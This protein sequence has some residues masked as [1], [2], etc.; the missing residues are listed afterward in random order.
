[1]GVTF[2][3]PI[4]LQPASGDPSINTTAQEFRNHLV[5]A[6]AVPVGFVQG[7][8]GIPDC[9]WSAGANTGG[10]LVTQRGAGA[11]FSVDVS[12][13]YC[14]INGTDVTSQGMYSCWNDGVVNVVTP[15]A[16]GSGTR[17]HR[18]VVQIQ[19][20]LSNG[21][22]TG[23]QA[24]PVLLQDTGGGTPGAGNSAIT[25]ALISITAGQTSVTNANITDY[26]RSV[27]AVVAYK[28]GSTNMTSTV[29]LADDPDLQLWGL[30][31]QSKYQIF[32]Q[33]YYKGPALGTADLKWTF[34]VPAGASGKYADNHVNVSGSFGW[35]QASNWTD[36]RSAGTEG[37]GK[38]LALVIMGTLVTG[39][40][41]PN[42]FCVF[43]AAQNTSNGTATTI[44]ANSTLR[45]VPVA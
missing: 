31:S 23:Y 44:E 8:G 41:T 22:W 5:A 25:L 19:D 6:L 13:G 34:R 24:V 35:E 12:A 3:T 9:G 15:G 20:K 10:L 29:A 38:D 33:I 16:P 1:L 7:L 40:T 11:N 14:Y 27:G 43:Q 36:T 30:Q 18:L 21:V 26:R 39:G 32:G 17:V 37:T 28:P 45:A 42:N 2:H 4:A